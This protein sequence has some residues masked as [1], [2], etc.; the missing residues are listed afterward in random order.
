ME[1]ARAGSPG[2]EF[3]NG[4]QTNKKNE[5]KTIIIIFTQYA[6]LRYILLKEILPVNFF[7]N[8][9]KISNLTL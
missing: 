7:P 5:Y 8:W 2:I 6:I 4:G 1:I 3:D 9:Q